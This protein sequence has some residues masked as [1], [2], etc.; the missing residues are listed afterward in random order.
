[1]EN[2]LYLVRA[3][4]FVDA[5]PFRGRPNSTTEYSRHYVTSD[6]SETLATNKLLSHLRA[7]TR[8]R[9]W[10]KSDVKELSAGSD[11]PLEKRI[12]ILRECFLILE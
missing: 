2:R 3:S 5:D 12:E 9:N 4:R 7:S 10:E 8:Y 6:R 11:I 1:M